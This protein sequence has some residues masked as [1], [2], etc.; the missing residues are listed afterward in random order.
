MWKYFTAN[1]TTYINVLTEIMDKYKYTYH[2]PIKC[3]PTL[4]REQLNY[5]FE[6]PYGGKKKQTRA[7][8]NTS[9]VNEFELVRRKRH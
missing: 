5:Q 2:R 3:K 4:V 9:W 7:P 6:A 1:N 8:E